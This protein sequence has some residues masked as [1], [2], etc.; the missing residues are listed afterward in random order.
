MKDPRDINGDGVVSLDEALANLQVPVENVP[1]PVEE[2]PTPIEVVTTPEITTEASE[3]VVEFK[4]A[5]QAFDSPDGPQTVIKSIDLKASGTEVI[6]LLGPSGCGKSTL[7]RMISGM[8]PLGVQMPTAGTCEINGEAVIHPHDDV[9]TAFQ[10]AVL[11]PWLTILDNVKLSFTPTTFDPGRKLP[12]RMKD[13][14]ADRLENTA[15]S[16]KVQR[17]KGGQE[18]HDRSVEILQQVGLGDALGKYPHQ[19][20]G[21]MKQRAALACKLV[22]RPPVLCMDEPFSK[23]D[24]G[25]REEMKDLFREL[26]SEYPCL[27]FLVTHYVDEA[28]ALADRVVIL[29]TRPATVFT[30]IVLPKNRPS[31]WSET[32]EYAI[33]EETILSA[34]REAANGTHGEVVVTL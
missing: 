29:S 9:V 33:F 15:L 32:P 1:A 34:M 18:I 2:T 13:W 27:T 4:G 11:A 21:G 7:L 16:G 24:P 12:H 31:N 10:T 8:H 6:A 25:L 3:I 26:K 20:S 19:L 28:L 17:S 22:V 5:S 14:L 23:L 30:E